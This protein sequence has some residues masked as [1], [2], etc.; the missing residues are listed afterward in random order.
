MRSPP[1]VEPTPGYQPTL[2]DR[3][4]PEGAL[5][6]RT[7][8]TCVLTFLVAGPITAAAAQYR[9]LTA[10]HPLLTGLVGGLAAA[11]V[12]YFMMSRMPQAA[13][14]VAQAVTL[15]TG[16]STPYES[17]FSWVESLEAR[18]DVAGALAAWERILAE[19]PGSA[20]PR[21]RAAELYAGRGADPRRAAQL[22]REVR[23]LP[24]VASRDALYATSRLVDL[25]DGALA[26]P[27]RALVELRRIV[28]QFPASPAATHARGA[29]PRLKAQLAEAADA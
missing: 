25:Y 8:V 18:G 11:A 28:E 9:P 24:G 27:G 15:P 1:P 2:L 13:G 20:A 17:Q 23:D 22:F 21:L 19:Q 29:I 14:D 5:V 6:I 12:M 26:E 3:L 16:K 7:R 10:P 4:G